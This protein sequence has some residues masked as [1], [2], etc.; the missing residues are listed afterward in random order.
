MNRIDAIRERSKTTFPF[1]YASRLTETML[2][3]SI[4]LRAGQGVKIE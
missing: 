1:E 2:L 4:P 3:G